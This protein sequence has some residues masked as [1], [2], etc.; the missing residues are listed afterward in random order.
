MSLHETSLIEKGIFSKVYRVGSRYAIKI[1]PDGEER[2]IKISQLASDLGIGPKV[3][4]TTI[5]NAETT[6]LMDRYDGTLDELI[7]LCQEECPQLLSHLIDGVID[8]LEYC[9]K[10][11]HEN[12]IVHN[13]FTLDN[14]LFSYNGRIVLTDYGLA[15]ISR[16]ERKR[17]TDWRFFHRL[18]DGL[19]EI[20][21]GRKFSSQ[22]ELYKSMTPPIILLAAL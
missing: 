18:R 14:I 16:D 13:D 7:Y 9:L 17:A 19:L 12:G 11:L 8:R 21:A 2:E 22:S 3:Y 1:T 20:R 6:I 4:A 10:V 5:N 15:Q